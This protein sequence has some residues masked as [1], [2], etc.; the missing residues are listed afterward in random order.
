MFELHTQLAKDCAVVGDLAL[1]RVLLMNDAQYP[2]LILVPRRADLSEVFDLTLLDQRQLFEEVSAVAAALAGFFRADKMNVAALGNVVPQ[3]HVHVIAR[4][5]TDAAWPRPVWGANPA[6]P[7]T[8]TELA[9]RLAEIAELL[10]PLQLSPA[11]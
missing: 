6:R 3:L 1:C 11:Q 9:D 2:W 4:H 10:Q 8:D 5:K 7:Y